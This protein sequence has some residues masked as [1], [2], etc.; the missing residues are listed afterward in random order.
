MEEAYKATL[1]QGFIDCYQLLG[2][3]EYFS[4][5]DDHIISESIHRIVDPD[6]SVSLASNK[7]SNNV[8]E[9]KQKCLSG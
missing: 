6:R 4:S 1:F 3:R 5:G 2:Q 7:C 9:L 8:H